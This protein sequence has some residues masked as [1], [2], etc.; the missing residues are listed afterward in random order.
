[1]T[2]ISLLPILILSSHLSV[3]LPEDLFPVGLPVKVLKTFLASSIFNFLDLITLN[4]LGEGYNLWRSSLWSFR[5][6]LDTLTTRQMR[7][8]I[9]PRLKVPHGGLVFRILTSWKN[10]STSTGVWTLIW[11]Y[12]VIRQADHSANEA[13]HNGWSGAHTSRCYMCGGNI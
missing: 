9:Y 12:S 4:T 2:P 11:E 7:Y 1:M 13:R 6:Q 3:G 8:G 5:Y 10:T